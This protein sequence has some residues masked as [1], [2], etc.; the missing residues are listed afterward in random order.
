MVTSA[1]ETVQSPQ[2]RLEAEFKRP[3]L[4]PWKASRDVGVGRAA[5]GVRRGEAQMQRGGEPVH[6]L[7]GGHCDWIRGRGREGRRGPIVG[8]MVVEAWPVQDGGTK[9]DVC[10]TLS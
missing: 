3:W 9:E 1:A 7:E 2:G 5:G 8:P 10:D 6:N 4:W